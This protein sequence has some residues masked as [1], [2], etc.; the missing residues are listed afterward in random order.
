DS[1]ITEQMFGRCCSDEFA[2][3]ISNSLNSCNLGFKFSPDPT[4]IYTD[5]A[6]FMSLVPECTNISVGYYSEHTNS[7]KQDLDFLKRLC[8]G[9]CL[10]D[11][12]NLPIKRDPS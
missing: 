12:E 6:K 1:V 8:K 11:W 2:K 5:S 9:V 4:G 7:E 3:A 10:V